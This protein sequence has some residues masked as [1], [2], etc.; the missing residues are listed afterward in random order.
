MNLLSHS[1]RLSPPIIG[2][3]IE[4]EHA[5]IG[6]QSVKDM[7]KEEEDDKTQPLQPGSASRSFVIRCKCHDGQ[8]EHEGEC[9]SV[10][11]GSGG[12]CFLVLFVLILPGVLCWRFVVLVA[13]R[14][15]VL[16]FWLFCGVRRKRER[17]RAK[18][19]CEIQGSLEMKISSP[20]MTLHVEAQFT[21]ICA[22]G[23]RY[24]TRITS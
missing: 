21:S 14:P 9:N 1:L 7:P 13:R 22:V 18:I 17:D 6:K 4:H 11:E 8:E 15:V 24:G 3:G 19:A 12:H 16:L 10:A 5:G 2:V 20:A 23:E